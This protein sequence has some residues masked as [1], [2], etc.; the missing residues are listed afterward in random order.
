[1]TPIPARRPIDEVG[2]IERSRRRDRDLEGDSGS[3]QDTE[4][5]IGECIVNGCNERVSSYDEPMP[6]RGHQCAR[7]GCVAVAGSDH[8]CPRLSNTDRVT[9]TQEGDP[10][11]WP[12][13]SSA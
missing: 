2:E 12:D 1:M 3:S 4:P 5:G 7:M 6:C 11:V 10:P 8:D 9:W 13:R